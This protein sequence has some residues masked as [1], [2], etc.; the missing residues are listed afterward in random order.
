M[1]TAHVIRTERVTD[2]WEWKMQKHEG[3]PT[4]AAITQLASQIGIGSLLTKGEVAPDAAV[5]ELHALYILTTHIKPR[6]Y[7][8][9][10]ARL[11]TLLYVNSKIPPTSRRPWR[12]IYANPLQFRFSE[13]G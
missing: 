2:Q 10:F 4:Y 12:D 1:W 9:Y 6:S 7:E 5:S 11:A 8:V 3:T 13:N